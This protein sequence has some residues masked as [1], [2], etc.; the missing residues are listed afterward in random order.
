MEEKVINLEKACRICMRDTMRRTKSIFTRNEEVDL[1]IADM[2]GECS[3]NQ[4]SFETVIHLYLSINRALFRH[5]LGKQMVVPIKS[6]RH[7]SKN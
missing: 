1:T 6:V 7:V 4:V 2:I 5:R 3:S